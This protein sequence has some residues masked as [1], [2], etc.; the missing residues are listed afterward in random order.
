MIE[1]NIKLDNIDYEVLNNE[2][3]IKYENNVLKIIEKDVIGALY[4]DLNCK[5]YRFDKDKKIIWFNKPSYKFL[6]EN[7]LVVE[8][9]NYYA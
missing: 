3:K 5:I 7:K 2:D 8:K 9:I 1:I 6:I 4:S